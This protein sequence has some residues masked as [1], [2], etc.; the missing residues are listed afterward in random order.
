MVMAAPEKWI[1]LTA[2][3]KQFGVSPSKLSLMVK[4]G[5]IVQTQR[6][7]KDERR[8]LLNVDELRRIFY[9]QQ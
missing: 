5:K 7:P 2:A 3:A 8:L 1:S 6:D 4:K 9:P